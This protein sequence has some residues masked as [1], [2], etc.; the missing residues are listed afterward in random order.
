M[1]AFPANLGNCSITRVEMRD[2][3]EGLQLA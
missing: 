1:R 3:A 2:I